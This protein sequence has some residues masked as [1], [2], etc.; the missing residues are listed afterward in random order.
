MYSIPRIGYVRH[1]HA[2]RLHRRRG[3]H[4]GLATAIAAVQHCCCTGS[5]SKA[6]HRDYHYSIM[7]VAKIAFVTPL[8]STAALAAFLVAFIDATINS[9][10]NNH[11]WFYDAGHHEAEFG[12]SWCAGFN[13]DFWQGYHKVIPKSPGWDD[14]HA[15]YTLYHYLNHYNLFGSGYYNQCHSML[16]RLTRGL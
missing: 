13:G 9:S 16:A 7:R 2:V 4:G 10:P 1:G 11:P 3:R 15:I 5:C 6:M 14:R 12:M 8:H